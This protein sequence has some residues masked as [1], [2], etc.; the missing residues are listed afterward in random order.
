METVSYRTKKM[1][2]KLKGTVMERFEKVLAS[3]TENRLY[4]RTKEHEQEE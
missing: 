3:G 2:M 4:R 1:T